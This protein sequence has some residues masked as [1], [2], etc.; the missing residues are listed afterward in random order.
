[1]IYPPRS[2]FSFRLFKKGC[3]QLHAKVCAQTLRLC[4][5][6]IRVVSL[7]TC[8][9]VKYSYRDVLDLCFVHF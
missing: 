4:L 8:G 3:C 6:G 5:S 2:F 1:M 9:E 7:S